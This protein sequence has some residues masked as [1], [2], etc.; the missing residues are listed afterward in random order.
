MSDKPTAGTSIGQILQGDPQ[1]IHLI[2]HAKAIGIEVV[3]V[4]NGRAET[5]LPYS[6]HLIG[7]PETG[8]IHGGAITSILDNVCGIAAGSALE[9]AT[10]MAT[11]DLR[12]DYM[13]PATPGQTVRTKAHCYKITKTVAFVRGSAFHD[14]EQDPIATCVGTFMLNSDGGRTAGANLKKS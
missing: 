9:E 12:I 4:E 3:R 13:K 14:D 5:I 1:L 10:S 7:D 11:L 6:D 2:P 8:V